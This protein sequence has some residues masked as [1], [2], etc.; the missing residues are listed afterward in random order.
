VLWKVSLHSTSQELVRQKEDDTG[1]VR[2]TY[3]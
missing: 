2:T 1:D 3:H